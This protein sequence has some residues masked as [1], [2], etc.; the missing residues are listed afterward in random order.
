MIQQLVFNIGDTRQSHTIT[1]SDDTVCEK[2]PN[3]HFFSDLFPVSGLITINPMR[4]T[5]VIN[6]FNESE[7]GELA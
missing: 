3:E 1:I 7:C 6:D 2:T 5:V 4:A